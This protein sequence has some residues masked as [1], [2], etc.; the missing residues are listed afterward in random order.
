MGSCV[1][2]LLWFRF[3][4]RCY[5]D[6]AA[7]NLCNVGLILVT[8][9]GVDNSMKIKLC[10]SSKKKKSASRH[11]SC[12]REILN[13]LQQSVNIDECWK[14]KMDWGNFGA[15]LLGFFGLER[16]IKEIERIANNIIFICQMCC[17]I[18]RGVEGNVFFLFSKIELYERKKRWEKWG[19]E[20]IS[21]K[22]V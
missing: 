14:Q 8:S 3:M 9:C 6:M 2:I 16:I 7:N 18:W 5:N 10:F 12:W 4:F 11:P 15:F 21:V 20:Y 19:W 17:Y 13:S 1:N 22:G